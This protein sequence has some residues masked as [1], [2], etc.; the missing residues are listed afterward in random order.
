MAEKTTF[1][2]IAGSNGGGIMALDGTGRLTTLD[3][4]A[5]GTAWGEAAPNGGG[6]DKF[7]AICG[8]MSGVVGY[9]T[10]GSALKYLTVFKS[11]TARWKALPA[12]GMAIACMTGS[13]TGTLVI[14]GGANGTQVKRIDMKCSEPKW[15]DCP[16]APDKVIAV[17]VDA[18]QAIVVVGNSPKGGRMSKL[19]PADEKWTEL[20]ELHYDVQG[21]CGDATNGFVVYGE[22]TLMTIQDF[23]KPAVSLP[24]PPFYIKAMTGSPKEGIATLAGDG[25]FVVYCSDL[26]KAAWTVAL[27]PLMPPPAPAPAPVQ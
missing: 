19:G 12:P 14:C 15:E 7:D 5:V 13:P 11:A 2:S 9:K 8:S 6:A 10:D 4:Y 16:P 27:G 17:S 26:S 3:N 18:S 20:L 1:V 25:D 21:M 24:R 23:S 22:G